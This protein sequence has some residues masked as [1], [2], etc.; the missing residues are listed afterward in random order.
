MILG[1]ILDTGYLWIWI[2]TW[3]A[4]SMRVPD[5]LLNDIGQVLYSCLEFGQYFFLVTA[6]LFG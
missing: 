5:I 3:D 2:W 6:A 1:M 4:C